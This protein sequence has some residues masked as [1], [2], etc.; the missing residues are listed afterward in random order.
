MLLDMLPFN[1]Y[2]GLILDRGHQNA[3]P[4]FAS[5]ARLENTNQTGQ[6]SFLYSYPVAALKVFIHFYQAVPNTCAN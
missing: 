6:R 2:P 3:D 1:Y 5:C 4:I